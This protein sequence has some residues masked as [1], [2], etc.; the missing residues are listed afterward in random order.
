M[1][2]VRRLGSQFVAFLSGAVLATGLAILTP[3]LL[4]VERP[5][6]WGLVFASATLVILGGG[7]SGWVSVVTGDLEALEIHEMDARGKDEVWEA[8]SSRVTA[9]LLFAL[10]LTVVGLAL[11][12]LRLVW[13]GWDTA[14]VTPSHPGSDTS[15]TTPPG[16]QGDLRPEPRTRP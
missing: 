16:A 2:I 5:P 14:P 6:L 15:R 9:L 10:V 7:V 1:R 11:L 12:P 3:V 4:E 8:E 13:H